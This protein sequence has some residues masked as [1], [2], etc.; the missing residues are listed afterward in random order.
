[1]KHLSATL[2]ATE[3]IALMNE[4]RRWPLGIM[5]ALVHAQRREAGLPLCAFLAIGHGAVVFVGNV[6]DF[7]REQKA[8]PRSFHVAL[9]KLKA[10]PF[11][12]FSAV[13]LAGWR[14]D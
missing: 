2:T 11:D 10:E 4:S 8:S 7:T 9:E 13:Y 1:M 5:L 12:S 3:Q 14:V 6:G